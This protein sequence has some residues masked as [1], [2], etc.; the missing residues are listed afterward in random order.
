MLCKKYGI[1]DVI[2]TDGIDEMMGGYWWHANES[3]R[4]STLYDAFEHFWSEVDSNHLDSLYRSADIAGVQI[5]LPYLDSEVIDYISRIPL[6]D[7]VMPGK[8]KHLWK[9]CALALK[10]PQ[11]VIDRPKIG[12]VDALNSI[13]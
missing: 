9:Q 8:P 12:F 13:K 5:H 1:T 7:R 4:F 2:A 10:V 11:W 6:E 3:D